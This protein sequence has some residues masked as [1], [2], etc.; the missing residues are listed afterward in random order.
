[1]SRFQ[2]IKTDFPNLILLEKT[3]FKD[4]RGYFERLF[5]SEELSN[6][7]PSNGTKQVNHSFTR[8]K[9]TVRGLHF[10]YP[11]HTETKLITCLSGAVFDVAVDLR[12]ESKTYLKFF[13]VE[14]SESNQR[15][16][17]IPEGFAHGFQSLEDNCSLI[18]F[19]SHE[20]VPSSESGLN[21]FDEKLSINWPLP[22]TGISEKDKL[23]P[24][25]T[26]EFKGFKI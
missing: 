4:Q 19:H 18:Y 10:Q 17:V 16:L 26:S 14:L 25:A 3:L 22:P 15:C 21:A 12:I 9:G 5:C 13:A 24:N 1:M 20:Y 6:A 11:P 7:F 23:L 2:V 8:H